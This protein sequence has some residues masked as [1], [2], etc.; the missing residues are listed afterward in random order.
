MPHML[1]WYLL[2]ENTT[3][4][5]MEWM[6][7]RAAGYNAGFAMVARP[8][9]IRN[10]P[11]SLSLLDAIREWEIARTE[12]AF[13]AAQQELLKDPRNE[14][15]LEKISDRKWNLYQYAMSNVFIREKFDRQPGEPVHTSWNFQQPWKE[16]PLQF[17]L[18]VMGNEGAVNNIKI[19]VDSYA[20]ITLPIELLAGESLVCD[21]TDLIRIYDK[22]GKPKGKYLLKSAAPVLAPGSHNIISD[23]SFKGE[24]PPKIEVLFKGLAKMEVVQSHLN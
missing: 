4:S 12:N 13:N 20:E 24:V 6:L 10:N 3:L 2:A 23:C 9:S 18:N 17:R 5:E 7:A 1:G 11:R 14:F 15:H 21:G 19:Q 22:N 16:Q 8:Q